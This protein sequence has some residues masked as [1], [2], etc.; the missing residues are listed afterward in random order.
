[1]GLKIIVLQD[2]KLF[3]KRT[4]KKSKSEDIVKA[5]SSAEDKN[6]RYIFVVDEIKK[7]V[8]C[9]IKTG[10]SREDIGYFISNKALTKG[11][12]HQSNILHYLP[13]EICQAL[14]GR[15]DAKDAFE[16]DIEDLSIFNND[17]YHHFPFITHQHGKEFFREFFNKYPLYK[18]DF[19]QFFDGEQFDI[20]EWMQENYS[21]SI[22]SRDQNGYLNALTE[23]FFCMF[24]RKE[25]MKKFDLNNVKDVTDLE[26]LDDFIIAEEDRPKP[27]RQQDNSEGFFDRYDFKSWMK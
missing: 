11:A 26:Y 4:D 27:P 17:F 23:Q 13:M 19:D 10:K 16:V 20:A 2:N 5:I 21:D 18:N 7:S 9:Y 22:F 6:I 25:V 1:M 3:V 12:A 8:Y 15:D 24:D 14:H